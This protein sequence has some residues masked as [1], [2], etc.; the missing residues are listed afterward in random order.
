MLKVFV[1]GLGL[2]VMLVE[3]GLLIYTSTALAAKDETISLL[4]EGQ[5][6]LTQQLEIQTKLEKKADQVCEMQFKLGIA[7]RDVLL[8]LTH[9]LGLT[10]SRDNAWVALL[11]ATGKALPSL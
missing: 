10:G 8:K 1:V 9:D 7:Y 6:L 4:K 5:Q 2:L 11:S 3:S